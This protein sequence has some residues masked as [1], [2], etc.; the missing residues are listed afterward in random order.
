[1]GKKEGVYVYEITGQ[2]PTAW[3]AH[4]GNGERSYNPKYKQKLAAQWQLKI[5]HSG[6]H[7][8]TGAVRVDFFFEVPIPKSMPKK[9]VARIKG[10]EKIY[11]TKRPDRTNYIKA[12]E[13]FLTGTVLFD[14]NIVVAGS[15][16]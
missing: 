12:N 15:A 5:Q 2:E 7:L 14:D 11:C 6:R 1:M 13:D 16:E 9:L 4:K 10:G 8:I 3:S